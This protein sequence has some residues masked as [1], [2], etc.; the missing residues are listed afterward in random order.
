MSGDTVWLAIGLGTGV[1]FVI[2]A[3]RRF[4]VGALAV[5]RDRGPPEEPCWTEQISTD[6]RLSYGR[7]GC[8]HADLAEMEARARSGEFTTPY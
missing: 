6:G 8:Y 5:T 2:W 3:W 4:D 7:Y 1:S